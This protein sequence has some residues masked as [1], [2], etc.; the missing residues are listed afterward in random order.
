MSVKQE[1]IAGG[2]NGR[3]SRGRFTQGN[4]GGPGNPNFRR[5][6][7]YRASIARACSPEDLE[8]VIQKLVEQAREGNIPA[9]R[10]LLDRVVGRPRELGQAVDVELPAMESAA[11]AV[12]A[13]N[14][15]LSAIAE[16]RATADEASR[17]AG[18]IEIARRT[19]ETAV[20][21][22][23]VAQLEMQAEQRTR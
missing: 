23:R 7:E 8:A 20:L 12:K 14:A 15:V 10:V 21:E 22:E 18:V 4:P 6:A 1:P 9:A 5:I 13:S 19:V 2:S 16:G 17:L 3:D 11:D